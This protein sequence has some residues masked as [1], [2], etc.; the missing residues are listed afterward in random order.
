MTIIPLTNLQLS[1]IF[2]LCFCDV[3]LKKKLCIRYAGT[4]I[5]L[6]ELWELGLSM[7]ALIWTELLALSTWTAN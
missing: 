6:K 4:G 7:V 3:Y 5:L 1:H 2:I